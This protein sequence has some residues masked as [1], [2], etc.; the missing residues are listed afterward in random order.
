MMANLRKQFRQQGDRIDALSLRE[1]GIMFATVLILLYFLASSLVFSPLR[2]RQQRLENELKLK[3]EQAAAFNTQTQA[4]VHAA[5]RDPD[6]ENE[7]RLKKLREQIGLMDPQLAGVSQSLVS[8]R[9]MAR[10]VEQ[11]LT[12]NQALQVLKVESLPPAPVD[13]QPVAIEAGA[14]APANQGVYKHGMRIEVRGRYIDLVKYLRALEA[15]P[16]KVFWG[17]V[18]LEADDQAMS[19]LTLVIYTLSLHQGWIGI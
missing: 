9:D 5:T 12:R 16:W 6:K 17:Q 11:V 7:A 15:M 8:P 13:G 4:I 2:I 14:A 10:F 19:K 3:Y 1:R 18:T